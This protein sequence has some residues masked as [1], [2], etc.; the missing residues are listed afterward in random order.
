MP[1]TPLPDGYSSQLTRNPGSLAGYA[2]GPG[3]QPFA[4]SKRL[5]TSDQLT[6]FHHASM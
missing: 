6:T 1:G 4:A 3:A 5:A 2:G